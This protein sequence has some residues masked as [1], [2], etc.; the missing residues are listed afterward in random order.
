VKRL[1]CL[2]LL[3]DRALAG[4]PRHRPTC[5]DVVETGRAMK[6]EIAFAVLAVVSGAALITAVGVFVFQ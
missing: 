6:V 5:Q 4:L 2:H 1:L 3:M